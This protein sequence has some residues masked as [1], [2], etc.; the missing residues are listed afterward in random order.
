[1]S[2]VRFLPAAR[3][4]ERK[5]T[6]QYGTIYADPPWKLSGGKN[7]KSG[8]SKSVSPDVHYPLLKTPEIMSM[9]VQDLALP[10]SHLYLWAVNGMLPDA[11]RV[12][13]AWGF[14]YVTNLCWDKTTGYGMGQYFRTDH[15]LLLFGVR[16]NP[17]YKRDS[18]GKKCQARSVIHAPRGRHSEKPAE[19]RSV[20]QHVSRGPYL[21][22]FCRRPASGWHVWGNEVQSDISLVV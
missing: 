6:L 15:E 8:F 14:R 4:Q 22:L 19:V 13:E 20:I 12:M 3:Q 11:L 16:G 17:G 9:P 21:E 10:D 18:R 7:G 1:M 2:E 5:V